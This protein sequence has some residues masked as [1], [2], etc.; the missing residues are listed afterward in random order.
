MMLDNLYKANPA[1]VSIVDDNKHMDAQSEEEIFNE[2][3]DTLT[4]LYKFVDGMN[5]EVDKKK[6]NQLF[7]NLYNEAQNLEV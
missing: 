2:A 5:T 1:N 3:E 6:L 4:S 7:A